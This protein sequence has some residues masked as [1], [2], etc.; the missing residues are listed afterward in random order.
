MIY[1]GF[2]LLAVFRL[3][4]QMAVGGQ[5]HDHTM[6]AEKQDANDT[7]PSSSANVSPVR[8]TGDVAPAV[9]A[10]DVAP[11]ARLSF[12]DMR[13]RSDKKGTHLMFL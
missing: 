3:Q 13:R 10:A 11:T 7:A 5:Q 9:T 4:V 12:P 1:H 2:P 6:A 8:N